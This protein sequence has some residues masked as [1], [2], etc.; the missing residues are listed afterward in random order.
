M[1]LLGKAFYNYGLWAA[2]S[3]CSAIFIGCAISV[4]CCVGFI[5][6]Q[7]T[8]DP[9]ELWVPATSRAEVEQEYFADEYGFFF[10]ID[11]AWVTPF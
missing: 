5:N 9:Q 11:T 1:G 4:A 2:R 6:Y 8:A 7:G 10:R 3:P